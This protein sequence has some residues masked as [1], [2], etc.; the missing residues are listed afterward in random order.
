[1]FTSRSLNRFMSQ[2]QIEPISSMELDLTPVSSK[3]L[4][5]VILTAT[6]A[7]G[8]AVNVRHAVIEGSFQWVIGRS[9][10]P[11]VILFTQI[12]TVVSFPSL[13]KYQLRT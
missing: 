4:S 9:V 13:F 6:L 12:G 3:M 2:L 11:S 8:T 5:S 10:T 1:M 7:D